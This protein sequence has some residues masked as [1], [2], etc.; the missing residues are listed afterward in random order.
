MLL[1]VLVL[2]MWQIA[3]FFF[4]LNG[5]CLEYKEMILHNFAKYQFQVNKRNSLSVSR[6][7]KSD[8][9]TTTSQKPIIVTVSGMPGMTAGKH[10]IYDFY[11]LNICM[12]ISE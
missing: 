10:V 1:H 8:P 9:V 11:Y 3:S 7:F 4:A 2:L 12:V 6:D 5:A